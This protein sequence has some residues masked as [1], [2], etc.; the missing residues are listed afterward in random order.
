MPG[1]Q[2][3]GKP[4]IWTTAGTQDTSVQRKDGSTVWMVISFLQMCQVLA[5][6]QAPCWVSD[7]LYCDACGSHPKPGA[8]LAESRA[9]GLKWTTVS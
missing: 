8:G 6:L 3:P 5:G 2:R 4:G 7:T 1:V 9:L